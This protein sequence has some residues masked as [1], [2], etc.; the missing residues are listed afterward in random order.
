[1]RGWIVKPR[2]DGGSDITT[3]EQ[4]SS[5]GQS[6]VQRNKI[7]ISPQGRVEAVSG[8]VLPGYIPSSSSGGA[9]DPVTSTSSLVQPGAST[10]P[11]PAQPITFPS[12]YARTG[13]AQTAANTL[14]PKLD[15]LHR[16]LSDTQNVSDPV[17]PAASDMPWFGDTFK[18]LTSWS[19]PGHVSTCPQP[20]FDLLGSH[21]VLNSH[22]QLI[23]DNFAPLRSA[24]VVAWLIL[25][26]FVVLRA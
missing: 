1:M 17:I 6:Q 14:A 10:Q 4:G 12:D 22:C 7:A 13:E 24:M 11:A 19:V 15:T 9:V 20:S 2:A 8:E 16:D 26:T 18:N 25:A 5:S 23:Q 21:Y 3:F